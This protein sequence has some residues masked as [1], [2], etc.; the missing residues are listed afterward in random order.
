MLNSLQIGWSLAKSCSLVCT[1]GMNVRWE[2]F[3]AIL[4]LTSIQ[5]SSL[6]GRV[7]LN[8]LHRTPQNPCL[9][10]SYSSFSLCRGCILR[11][12]IF[13]TFSKVVC[14]IFFFFLHQKKT[15]DV[16]KSW[17]STVLSLSSVLMGLMLN[18]SFNRSCA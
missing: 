14:V 6:R 15:L 18:S 5:G 9:W 1:V 3:A 7:V 11:E 13:S 10:L 16:F 4:D 17:I 8:E 12:K 2:D